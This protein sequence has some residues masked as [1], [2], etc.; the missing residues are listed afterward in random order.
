MDGLYACSE[1]CCVKGI[2]KSLFNLCSKEGIF[3]GFFLICVKVVERL[4][5]LY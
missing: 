3:L 1:M 4:S 2:E 5:L